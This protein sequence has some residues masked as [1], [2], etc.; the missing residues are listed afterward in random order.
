MVRATGAVSL[1]NTG[2]THG[3][4]RMDFGTGLHMSEKT[5]VTVHAKISA[6]TA[7]IACQGELQLYAA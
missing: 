2:F 4:F 6:S 5:L 7:L 3:T 1:D